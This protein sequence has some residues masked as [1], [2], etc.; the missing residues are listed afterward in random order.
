MDGMYRVVQACG[1][2]LQFPSFGQ[3]LR[4]EPGS[5]L[6]TRQAQALSPEWK[7][8]RPVDSGSVLFPRCCRRTGSPGPVGQSAPS[9]PG[10]DVGQRPGSPRC[11]RHPPCSDLL[12]S[13]GSSWLLASCFLAATARRETAGG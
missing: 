10:S 13:P 5:R 12:L 4:L 6:P 8:H 3:G 2:E 11:G 1:A 9:A 7:E